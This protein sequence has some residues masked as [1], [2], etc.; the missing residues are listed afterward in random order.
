MVAAVK[1]ETL[2]MLVVS[3]IM[4]V[5]VAKMAEKRDPG[6]GPGPVMMQIHSLF[7]TTNSILE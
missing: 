3:T 2:V 6:G 1:K 4:A 5:V 7:P